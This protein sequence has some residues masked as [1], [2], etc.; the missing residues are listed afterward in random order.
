MASACGSMWSTTR[1]ALVVRGGSPAGLPHKGFEAPVTACLGGC[2][3]SGQAGVPL[4]EGHR[5]GGTVQPEGGADPARL[6][7]GQQFQRKIQVFC[8][9]Q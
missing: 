9:A 8:C 1:R 5:G 7:P 3:E 2:V 6:G 4:A